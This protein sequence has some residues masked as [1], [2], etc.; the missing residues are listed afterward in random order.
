[1]VR[2]LP[3]SSGDPRGLGIDGGTRA[4]ADASALRLGMYDLILRRVAHV[5]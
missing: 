1:M 3:S 4:D 5:F 2:V